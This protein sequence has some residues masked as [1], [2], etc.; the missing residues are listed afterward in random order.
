MANQFSFVI[1]IATVQ[2][3]RVYFPSVGKDNRPISKSIHKNMHINE[4]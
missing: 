2:D 3:S 1:H 4:P